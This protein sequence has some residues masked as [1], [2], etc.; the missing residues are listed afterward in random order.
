MLPHLHVGYTAR[1]YEVSVVR[2]LALMARSVT[3]TDAITVAARLV[4]QQV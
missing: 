3:S 2:A 4:A 1:R